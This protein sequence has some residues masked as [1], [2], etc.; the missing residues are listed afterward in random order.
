[1]QLQGT[2]T[3]VDSIG[4]RFWMQDETGAIPIANAA[5][6]GMP[7][8][9]LGSV[10]R[11]TGICSA[12]ADPETAYLLIAKEPVGFKL[13]VRSP[14]DIQVVKRA[15]WWS[16]RHTLLLLSALMV[17]KL[18]S[19]V[20]VT[21]LRRRVQKQNAALR[22]AG[23]KS[24]ALHA[25]TSAMQEVRTR[26]DFS[27]R[28]SASGGEE[29]A[30]LG[31]EFNTMLAELEA[32]DAAKTEAEAKLQMQAL[33]DELTGLP[34]RRL[35]S[36]RVTQ[37]LSRAQRDGDVV[38]L[39]Y[40]DLD[41]FKLVNDS[42]GHSIGDALLGQVAERLRARIR[43]ADTLARIGGDEFTVVLTQLHHRDEARIVAKT[44]LDAL[45]PPFQVD[46]HE[47]SLRASAGIS[48]SSGDACDASELLQEADSAMYAAKRQGKNRML[49]FEPEMR[50]LLR[51]RLTV[52]SQLRGAVSRGEIHLHYQPEFDLET[53]QLVRFEA[54]A[55]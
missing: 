12:Q 50:S 45:T 20:W 3:Y 10:L 6:S 30:Q 7:Q 43:K 31:I 48:V 33:T 28:V 18:T 21:R 11:L 13:V 37:A 17:T 23:E 29:I 38:A 24:R 26:E 4:H 39:V 36:D 52:E 47:I 16:I 22:E 53:H 51:E 49:Y 41:G 54:L 2:V 35:F 42:L 19:I 46:G 55:R 40:L 15:S 5:S 1:V 44:L 32:R 8:F 25:L 14:E 9:E 34:N 27:A